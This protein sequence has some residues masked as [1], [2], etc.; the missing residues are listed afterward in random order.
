MKIVL[1]YEDNHGLIEVAKDYK[2]T[3]DFL[4]RHNWIT[5]G[6]EIYDEQTNYYVRLKEKMD[7]FDLF[8][9]DIDDF[10][11]YFLDSFKL[12]EVEVYEGA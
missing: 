7:I 1:V 5:E 6:T 10:N 11:E 2:S 3:I 9:W 12:E 4:I 8:N